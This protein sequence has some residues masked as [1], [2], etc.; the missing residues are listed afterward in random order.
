MFR[1]L[2]AAKTKE[3]KAKIQKELEALSLQQHTLK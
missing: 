1:N 3:D 2:L